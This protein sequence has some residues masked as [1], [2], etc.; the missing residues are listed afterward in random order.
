MSLTKPH[1]LWLTAGSS[2]YQVSMSTVQAIMLSGRYRT[3]QL[4]SKWSGRSPNCKLC[5]HNEPE[6]LHHILAVC[7][8][9]EPTRK[10]LSRF[11]NKL[12]VQ[13]PEVTPIVQKYCVPT[14]S[15]FIQFLVDCSVLPDVIQ[16]SQSCGT[17][18]HI[19][20]FRLT[21]T[22]CYILHKTRLKLLHCWKQ[23]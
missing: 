23:F 19:P 3:E 21:R 6:N 22:W 10:Q 17:E 5:K 1:P 14:Y 13:Y 4:S 15:L 12:L 9:L 18:I 11:T 8:S 2:S 16:L 7:V 20:L